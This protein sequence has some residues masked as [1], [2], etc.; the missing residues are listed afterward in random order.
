VLEQHERDRIPDLLMAPL[1][2]QLASGPD[3]FGGE[4]D[5]AGVAFVE[6]QLEHTL[7]RDEVTKLVSRA[8]ETVR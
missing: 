8:R 7:H 6:D 4:V 1:G 2:V 5:V 3:G